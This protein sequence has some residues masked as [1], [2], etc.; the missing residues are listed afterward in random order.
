MKTNASY[1][2]NPTQCSLPGLATDILDT[3]DSV[4]GTVL[5]KLANLVAKYRP[6]SCTRIGSAEDLYSELYKRLTKKQ[7][8]CASTGKAVSL[9]V[10]IAKNLL[11]DNSRQREFRSKIAVPMQSLDSP[12]ATDQEQDGGYFEFSRACEAAHDAAAA[13]DMRDLIA[14]ASKQLIDLDCIDRAIFDSIC[15]YVTHSQNLPNDREIAESVGAKQNTV[16]VRRNK[17]QARLQDVIKGLGYIPLLMRRPT[18]QPPLLCSPTDPS[19][20]GSKFNP[21]MGS[22]EKMHSGPST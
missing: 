2:L 12:T 20:L 14:A 8:A 10:R 1:L 3:Y 11:A 16:T 18:C 22:R 15:D 21:S 7:Y 13:L 19:G 5:G 9:A 17:L 6:A 4:R